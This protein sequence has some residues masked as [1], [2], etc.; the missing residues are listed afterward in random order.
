LILFRAIKKITA[1]ERNLNEGHWIP[2]HWSAWAKN[3]SQT[4]KQTE[5]E[6]GTSKHELGATLLCFGWKK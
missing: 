4:N 2:G 1:T 3:L 6:Q 5:K